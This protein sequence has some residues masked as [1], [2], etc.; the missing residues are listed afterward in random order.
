L[1]GAGIRYTEFLASTIESFGGLSEE[2]LAEAFDRLDG[3]DTGYI[4]AADLREILGSDF[5]KDEINRIMKEASLSNPN[6]ISYPEF[7]SLWDLNQPSLRNFVRK[8]SDLTDSNRT[9][10]IRNFLLREH[11]ATESNASAASDEDRL[12]LIRDNDE[13][14]ADMSKVNFLQGKQ[15]S[16]RRFSK[17]TIVTNEDLARKVLFGSETLPE[18][19]VVLQTLQ[20]ESV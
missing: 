13:D 20:E 11:D 17:E 19:S 4:S 16:E 1:D 18:E 5:P 8:G 10:S 12:E 3:D 15:M 7:L 9:A 2:R 6:R 14:S